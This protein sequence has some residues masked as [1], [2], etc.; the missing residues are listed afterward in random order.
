M[1][2]GPEPGIQKLV[3][4]QWRWQEISQIRVAWID[5]SVSTHTLLLF[6][7]VIMMHIV[8]LKYYLCFVSFFVSQMLWHVALLR[9]ILVFIRRIAC[10]FDLIRWFFVYFLLIVGYLINKFLSE[11]CVGSDNNTE[12][13]SWEGEC[14][15]LWDFLD[16]LGFAYGM[17]SSYVFFFFFI[18]E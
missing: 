12:L 16:S 9:Y 5:I 17:L 10:T 7:R 18:N 8:G 14:S 1:L 4:L 2:K 13:H 11:W 6:I 15:L 3:S